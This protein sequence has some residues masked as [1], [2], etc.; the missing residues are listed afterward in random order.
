MGHESSSIRDTKCTARAVPDATVIG[1]LPLFNMLPLPVSISCRDLE[2]RAITGTI[3]LELY[4]CSSLTN[5]CV[6]V[7]IPI[8]NDRMLR[9]APFPFHVPCITL[10]QL[11]NEMFYTFSSDV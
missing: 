3:P 9:G 11:K 7:H 10:H 5:V 2:N 8:I 1:I 4:T 6:L